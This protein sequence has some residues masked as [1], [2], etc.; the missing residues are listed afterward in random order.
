M[1]GYAVTLFDAEEQPGGMLAHG[2]PEY[3]LPAAMA[4]K[5]VGRVLALGVAFVGGT[6][7]GRDITITGLA[8]VFDAVY[9]AIGAHR[10]RKLELAG[11]EASARVIDALVYLRS[12]RVGVEVPGGARVVVIGGGNA[13]IDAARTALRRGAERVTIACIEERK[14]MP[15]LERRD[16]RGRSRRDRDPRAGFVPC[17][18]PGTASRSRRCR[19]RTARRRRSRPIS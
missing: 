16:R 10:P 18:G 19:P 3:R 9:V 4:K 7:L 6:R 12:V 1:R 13:A 11:D 17:A 15:A 5:D 2:I 8:D 14:A